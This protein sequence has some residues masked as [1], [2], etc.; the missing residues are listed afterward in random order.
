[1]QRETAVG[2]RSDPRWVIVCFVASRPQGVEMKFAVLFALSILAAA[3]DNNN[4]T[5]KCIEGASVACACPTGGSGAQ[6]CTSA[7]AFSPCSCSASATPPPAQT[8]TATPAPTPTAT[9]APA[10][11]TPPV[12]PRPAMATSTH[13]APAE[14]PVP[15]IRETAEDEL[16]GT[17]TG[18]AEAVFWGL[19]ESTGQPTSEAI[20]LAIRRRGSDLVAD[21]T[22]QGASGECTPLRRS[23]QSSTWIAQCGRVEMTYELREGTLNFNESDYS[24]HNS[25]T[26]KG[27]LTRAR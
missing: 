16:I 17:W 12:S 24:A 2:R 19:P 3:C 9:P 10:I 5:P 7:G 4:G 1:M 13:P 25:Y 27:A 26:I 21:R 22:A 23:T 15:R 8:P 11:Q 18:T 6:V 14:P 20:V